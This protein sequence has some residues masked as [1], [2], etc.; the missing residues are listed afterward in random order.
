MPKLIL[1][2]SS[3][4][5]WHR[6]I[7]DAERICERELDEAGESYLV[8]LLMRYAA[9]PDLVRAVLALRYLRAA[10][11]KGSV[12]RERLQEVGDHC[13]I[14]AG[15]FPGQAERRRVRLRYFVDIG[16][17]AYHQVAEHS[18]AG[19][20]DLFAGLSATFVDLMDV[21]QATRRIHRDGSSSALEA[22]ETWL[23][24][25]SRSA[26]ERLARHT[27][28]FPAPAPGERTRH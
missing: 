3:T 11:S 5:S 13:L 8:F 24:T 28:G 16:R 10:G 2:P 17:S 12:R 23:E 14:Y 26:R 19:A 9:H 25:G 22:F 15:L 20:A 4:A 7:R 1:D 21:L 6:L 18:G 27:E